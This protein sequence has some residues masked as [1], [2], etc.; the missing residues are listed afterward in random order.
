[1]CLGGGLSRE[2]LNKIKGARDRQVGDL[3]T[4]LQLCAGIALE[5]TRFRAAHRHRIA[6][7][8]EE[9]PHNTKHHVNRDEGHPRSTLD[10][11]V[12]EGGPVRCLHGQRTQRSK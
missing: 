4:R 5:Q 3:S 2:K 1:M 11:L 10:E 9:R 8:P 12:C 6:L 7:N